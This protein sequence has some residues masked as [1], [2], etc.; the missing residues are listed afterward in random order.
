MEIVDCLIR[1]GPLL[2][3]PFTPARFRF[4]DNVLLQLLKEQPLGASEIFS[5]LFKKNKASR[6]FKFLDNET[7]LIEELRLISSLQT[8]PFL[9]AAL[10][11]T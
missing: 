8:L 9:K 1:K 7:S 4:Y 5:R 3:L 2:E 10:R 6:I 11:V